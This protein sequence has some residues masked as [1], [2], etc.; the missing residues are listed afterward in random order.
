MLKQTRSF[1]DFPSVGAALDAVVKM[2]EH[3]LKE[4]NPQV[5]NITYDINDLYTFLDG[6]HDICALV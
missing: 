1:M 3:K 5:Q 6:L 2:Y 4:L